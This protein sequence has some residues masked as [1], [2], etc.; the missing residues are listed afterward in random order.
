MQQTFRKC[1][2]RGAGAAH[3]GRHALVPGNISY[4]YFQSREEEQEVRIEEPPWGTRGRSQRV[5]GSYA[6]W[7]SH[8]RACLRRLHGRSAVALQGR[9]VELRRRQHHCGAMHDER[10]DRD[11]QVG[12]G[13]PEL[14]HPEVALR[15]CR[16]ICRSL[17]PGGFGGGWRPTLRAA[18]RPSPRKFAAHPWV[19][20]DCRF[21]LEA[22]GGRCQH[23]HRQSR[24]GSRRALGRMHVMRGA[25]SLDFVSDFR[26]RS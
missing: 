22:L 23:W 3:C 11:G 17:T 18:L 26:L 21:L 9:Q 19:R 5:T 10:S 24:N 8:D 1:R 6:S 15:H 25:C 16:P 12:R 2:P 14:G 4:P 13:A 20:L 7:G